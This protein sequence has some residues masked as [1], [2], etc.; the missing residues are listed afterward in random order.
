MLDLEGDGAIDP[1][2]S[3]LPENIETV[4]VLRPTEVEGV[5]ETAPLDRIDREGGRVLQ[6][7]LVALAKVLDL[8]LE[9]DA[10]P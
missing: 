10:Q 8:P 4:A 7:L 5:H 3:I 2:F 6:V 9:G 1:G